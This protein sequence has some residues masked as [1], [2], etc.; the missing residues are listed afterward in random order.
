MKKFVGIVL[1]LII[2]TI[3]SWFYLA[4][5]YPTTSP[6]KSSIYFLE[7]LAKPHAKMEREVY[8]FLPYWQINSTKNLR[9]EVLTEINYFGLVVNNEG[10]FIKVVNN[11]TDPGFREWNSQTIKDLIAKTQIMGGKF[12]VAR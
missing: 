4:N 6:L 5:T 8:G 3:A 11:Q 9:L 1:I 7:H 2:I 12:S 10:D